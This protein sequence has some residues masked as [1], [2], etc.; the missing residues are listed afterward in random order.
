MGLVGV[1]SL[2]IVACGSSSSST[3]SGST[4]S[5]GGSATTASA[6]EA[7]S[8]TPFKVLA[9]LPMSGPLAVVGELAKAGYEQAAT[10]VN[11]EG[12]IEGHKV[13][14][15]IVDD[16]G[17]GEK[18]V[19]AVN[20]AASEE[21]NLISCG[22]FG[23]DAIPC[24][25]A[26][27]S[28]PALQIPLA[29]EK[30]LT[31]YEKLP[32]VFVPGTLF[33]PGEKAMAEQIQKDGISKVAIVVGDGTTGHLGSEILKEEAEAVGLEVATTVY[34]PEETNDATPQLQQ[35]ESSGAEA[36]AISGYTV[37][38][39]PILAAKEKIGWKVPVYGDWYFSSANLGLL[40]KPK[41]F[42]EITMEVWPWDI[43]GDPATK[44]PEFQAFYPPI[45]KKVPEPALSV[46]SPLVAFQPLLLARAA[47]EKAGSIEGPKLVEAM[48]EVESS[49]EIKGWVGVSQIYT[50]TRHHFEAES[51]EFKF[52]PG[53]P[54]EK[55]LIV[56][57]K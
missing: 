27:V 48:S 56:P 54:T 13:E 52:I 43:E 46:N 26:L 14:L 28:N 49:S 24:A 31:D 57:A 38:N 36:I 40:A 47:A 19:T 17:S 18:A 16:A 20:N 22:D 25:E 29:A 21:F 23:E 11:A 39:G 45:L 44:T 12:G 35:A 9:V 34:V 15:K 3:S 53:A 50:P 30:T 41:Q 33:N 51:S 55:G 7:A 6:G 42:P 2:A 1:L 37:A 10:V 4:S 32:N 8:G 5:E